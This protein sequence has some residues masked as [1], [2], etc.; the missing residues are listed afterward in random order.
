M[1]HVQTVTSPEGT[2]EV[3]LCASCTL[4]LFDRGVASEDHRPSDSPCQ[5]CER[6]RHADTND[7][8]PHE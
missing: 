1:T 4:D 6:L 8:G 7:L 3:C 5:R 2:A